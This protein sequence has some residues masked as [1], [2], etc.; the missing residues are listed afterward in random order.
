MQQRHQ[1]C[2]CVTSPS[3][4][5]IHPRLWKAF[6]PGVF[7]RLVTYLRTWLWSG[8]KVW[9]MLLTVLRTQRSGL[10][11]QGWVRGRQTYTRKEKQEKCQMSRV[12]K[13]R[14]QK[15]NLCLAK[16]TQPGFKLVEDWLRFPLDYCRDIVSPKIT[17][18]VYWTMF[19]CPAG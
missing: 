14:S 17:M 3:C 11:A 19:F 12:N 18:S 8:V 9:L 5:G 6:N 7:E 4:C 1:S 10:G 2:C 15:S 16:E 13:I